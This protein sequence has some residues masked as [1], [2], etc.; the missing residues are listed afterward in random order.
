MRAQAPIGDETPSP[1]LKL[2]Q[3]KKYDYFY[4]SEG[5][6]LN[7][8][9]VWMGLEPRYRIKFHFLSLYRVLF[10]FRGS[11]SEPPYYLDGS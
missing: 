2:L 10:S 5:L 11:I 1:S 4:R 8:H 7:P 9:I 3:F 6:F